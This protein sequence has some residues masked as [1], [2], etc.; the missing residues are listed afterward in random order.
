MNT[1]R[2]MALFFTVCLL[3]PLHAMAQGV[4]TSFTHQGRLLDDDGAPITGA[5]ELTYTIYDAASGGSI[6]WQD[7]VSTVL[8]ESGFF[9]VVLGGS[10]NPINASVLSEAGHWL[11]V[12]VN[13]GAELTP[14]ISLTSVPFAVRAGQAGAV[15][16]GAVTTAS[17]A[18]DF[19]LPAEMIDWAGAPLSPV[20]FHRLFTASWLFDNAENFNP[21]RGRTLTQANSRLDF[22]AGGS[23]DNEKLFEVT[24]TPAGALNTSERYIVTIDAQVEPLTTDND[25]WIGLSD[26]TNV[27]S[28][29]FLDL[30]NNRAVQVGEF[31]DGS[32]ITNHT[33]LNRG[34]AHGLTLRRNRIQVLLGDQTEIYG[35]N[36]SGRRPAG[37]VASRVL[38]RDHAMKLVV[39]AN[40]PP[41]LY[42][43]YNIEVKIER[44]VF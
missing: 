7:E 10:T 25:L 22:A 8:G 29:H 42:G 27:V 40:N 6:L 4:P 11:G 5:V 35:Y 30:N 21:A 32:V 39:F 18:E 33:E 24:L 43:V 34:D 15:A 44:E 36:D 16:N 31:D 3:L 17:L 12:G 26:G 38:N 19:T 37:G 20:V 23:V 9:S 13:N 1:L 14:R 2:T 41:E 28:A